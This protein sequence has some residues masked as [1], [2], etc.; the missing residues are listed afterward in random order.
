[1]KEFARRLWDHFVLLGPGE[2]K[3]GG[4]EGG[5]IHLPPFNKPLLAQ[6]PATT[7]DNKQFTPLAQLP[8]MELDNKFLSDIKGQ[9]SKDSFFQ[10]V[11]D[12]PK[13]FRN[14]EVADGLVHIWLNDQML[15]C[16]LNVKV[17][18]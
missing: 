3:E 12:S 4:E 18:S 11:L 7:T 17:D 15:T 6:Q 10:K 14:F 2:Q 9:Y 16:I 8:R 5:N 13:Q 1:M